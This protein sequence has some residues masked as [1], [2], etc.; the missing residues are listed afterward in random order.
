MKLTLCKTYHEREQCA[1]EI[2]ENAAKGLNVLGF[3]IELAPMIV[4]LKGKRSINSQLLA[5]FQF[6][7]E[8]HVWLFHIALWEK[9]GERL[10]GPMLQKLLTS[11]HILKSGIN[12]ISD[13][14]HVRRLLD[15][16][17]RGMVE[18]DM[19]YRQ[20]RN[21]LPFMTFLQRQVETEVKLRLGKSGRHRKGNW[22]VPFTPERIQYAANDAYAGYILYRVLAHKTGQEAPPP[23]ISLIRPSDPHLPPTVSTTVP[24]LNAAHSSS[25][26]TRRRKAGLHTWRS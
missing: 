24:S 5:L 19:L 7:S 8:T 9:M 23:P 1:R 11:E 17:M 15:V 21:N 14:F 12:I 2:L 16:M 10:V 20:T 18:L 6:A 22:S 26:R 25:C 4:T 3:D 13:E